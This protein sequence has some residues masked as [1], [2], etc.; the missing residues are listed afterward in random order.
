[1]GTNVRS[2][3]DKELLTRV[4]G[5][6][7]YRGIPPEYWILGVRSKEDEPNKFDDKFY[8]FKGDKF[9][10]VLTGSTNTGTYGLLNWKKWSSEGAAQIKDNEWYYDVWERGLHKGK[11]AALRQ[12]GP[13]KV[14]RDYNNNKKSG[15]ITKWSWERYKGLNFHPNTYN[16]NTTVKKWTIGKWSV[17]CQTPNDIPK[18][19]KF[20]RSSEPQ[21]IF[22]YC[23]IKEF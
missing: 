17:G 14:I 7:S 2:Y 16:L 18:Y 13:F 9:I 4:K 8:I 1:M 11:V 3:T 19:K 21:D 22:T 5:L 15:D 23:L 12:K 6:V 10:D 20:M